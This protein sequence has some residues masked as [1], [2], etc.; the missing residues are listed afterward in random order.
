M[1]KDKLK[2]V[3][4]FVF[5]LLTMS[6]LLKLY[7][8]EREYIRKEM[9]YSKLLNESRRMLLEVDLE[10]NKLKQEFLMD[11]K[12]LMDRIIEQEEVIKG[13]KEKLKELE[14]FKD[15]LDTVKKFSGRNM[16]EEQAVVTAFSIYKASRET[17]LDWKVLSA[18]IMT[19]SSYRANIVSIDPAYGLMQLKLPT[20]NY[21]AGKVGSK[22]MTARELLDIQNNVEFGSKYLLSQVIKFSSLSDGIMAYN[23][24]PGRM[25]QLK[26][27]KNKVFESRYLKK[28][29]KYHKKIDDFLTGQRVSMN[30]N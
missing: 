26:K 9:E 11:E 18:L 17:K 21:M 23:F 5:F 16:G 6:L 20:A 30:I 13:Q 4:L 3:S 8:K 15:I 19:E 7:N 22:K 12:N 10:K 25:R 24:G 14:E 28:I 2:L 29:K 27:E 1:N